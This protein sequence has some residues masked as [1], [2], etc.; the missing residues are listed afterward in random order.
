[1]IMKNK[2]SGPGRP[3]NENKTVARNFRLSEKASDILDKV[4]GR[5]IGQLLSKLIEESETKSK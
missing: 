4:E 1:M 3:K 5:K 2:Q